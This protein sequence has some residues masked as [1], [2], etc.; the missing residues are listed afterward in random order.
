MAGMKRFVTYIY[1]YEEGQRAGNTGFAKLELRGEDCRME[2]HLRGIPV[3]KAV[4]R[5][6]FMRMK[7][8]MMEGVPVGELQL[9]NGSGDFFG[10]WKAGRM[11]DSALAFSDM[12][13]IFLM[14]EDERIFMSRWKEG[15]ALD[16]RK[17]NFRI[18]TEEAPIE[19]ADKE[20]ASSVMEAAESIPMETSEETTTKGEDAEESLETR[21]GEIKQTEQKTQVQ[22]IEQERQS[23]QEVQPEVQATEVPVRNL[24]PDYEW[25]DVWETLLENLKCCRQIE[26]ERQSKQEVQPEVQATEVPVRNLFPDYE[27][28]DVWETLLENL[29]CC[30]PFED[31]EAECVQIELKH[32]RELPKRYWYLG[33][34]SF[35]LH[36]FFNY[37]YLVV[38]RTGEGRWFLGVPGIYQRQERVMAA[39]FGFP[40]FIAAMSEETR[41][42]REEP[43]NR[44]GC[45][46][47]YIEE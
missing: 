20:T 28:Q 23:K 38:G 47:R 2:I 29:K 13:G 5:V 18:W 33:N 27:W 8:E 12:D 25:Q 10:S 31:Q 6:H 16:V 15:P 11:G 46:Y 1:A 44:M 14:T 22:E 26:Q 3:R 39:I 30:R 17:E 45:W 24:F 42:C 36:G 9:I 4:C 19:E 32:L 37:H 21:A 40:E 7:G 41:D 35:L 34:N 43:V